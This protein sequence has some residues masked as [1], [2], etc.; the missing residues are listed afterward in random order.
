MQRVRTVRRSVLLAGVLITIGAA[1][2]VFGLISA[3]R[4]W[5]SVVAG[6]AVVVLGLFV[7]NRGKNDL[8]SPDRLVP[9]GEAVR[10]CLKRGRIS[11]RRRVYVF[12][13]FLIWLG[14]LIALAVAASRD[15]W[16]MVAYR[17]VIAIAFALA[18]WAFVSGWIE[19]QAAAP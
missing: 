12:A 3:N 11:M 7:L 1:G 15:A 16:A 14:E 9:P 10:A 13:A 4:D 19:E 8:G 5:P 2:F 17:S 18:A 6:A